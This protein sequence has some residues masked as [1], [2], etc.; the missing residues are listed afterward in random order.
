MKITLKPGLKHV[1]LQKRFALAS[2]RY[3]G[4]L[5]TLVYFTLQFFAYDSSHFA[6]FKVR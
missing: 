5:S 3:A 4:V 1:F 2:L 6:A